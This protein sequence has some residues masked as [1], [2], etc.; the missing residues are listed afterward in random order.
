[1]EDGRETGTKA[2]RMRSV[3]ATAALST[4]SGPW[5]MMHR[6]LE[7]SLGWTRRLAMTSIS[8]ANPSTNVWT[9]LWFQLRQAGRQAGVS[10]LFSLEVVV[11]LRATTASWSCPS[12]RGVEVG[13]EGVH[14]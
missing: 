1:M 13:E 12:R 14:E 6:G 10:D 5:Q 2:A 8:G 3:H 7:L 4:C 9:E 11:T